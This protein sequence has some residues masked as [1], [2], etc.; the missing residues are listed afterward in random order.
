MFDNGK[1]IGCYRIVSSLGAGGMGEV[2]LAND[3]RLNRK[4][5]LKILPE[6]FSGNSDGLNR[7]RQEALAASALN[8]P[9]I[10][11]VFDID[12]FEG[13][14]FI[15]AEFIKGQTLRER[16]KNRLTFD[17]TLSITIQTAEALSAAHQA[18][19]VHRDIKPENVMVRK[20]GYVKVLDF[21][22]AKLS[23]QQTNGNEAGG[24]FD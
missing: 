13:K 14:N 7:F 15:A 5:A 23:E 20:D 3:T 16:M 18:G 11:T 21:G 12:E 6:K 17:K 24:R 1:Q 9:N 19:I 22:L 8:H 4:V 10:I 2:F